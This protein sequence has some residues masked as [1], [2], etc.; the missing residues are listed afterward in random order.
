MKKIYGT[1]L[2]IGNGFDLNLGMVTDYRSFFKELQRIGFF[3]KNQTNPLLQFIQEK[4]VKENWYDF[5]NIIKEYA[6]KSPQAIFIKM[7]EDFLPKLELALGIDKAAFETIKDFQPLFYIAP[8]LNGIIEYTSNHTE[9]QFASDMSIQE[10]CNNI[11]GTLS[12]YV[13]EQRTFVKKAI[14]LL[15]TELVSYLK[16]ASI[17]EETPTAIWM[18]FAI[19]GVFST[20][21]NGL[22][23]N[24]IKY[25]DEHGKY[26]F[27]NFRIVSFNYTDTVTKIANWLELKHGMSLCVETQDLGIAFYRIHGDLK[28]Q[29]VF[30]IDDKCSIPK[31]FMFLRK[32]Q[33][34]SKDA[35]AIF[36]NIIENSDRIIIL[37][38]SIY[39]I[40]FEYYEDFFKENKD[41][42]VV[43]LY[44]NDSA[45]EA[46]QRGL[47]KLGVE[48][49]ITY[50]PLELSK[51]FRHYCEQIAKDQNKHFA[52]YSKC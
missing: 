32:S 34:I 5:E 48:H 2:I 24:F 30:G 40:D 38:H 37:G 42:E 36:R 35:K 31:A 50:K 51:T 39:G 23:E 19:M 9:Y 41:T 46:I 26:T 16:K 52:T 11:E 3:E 28:S 7:I 4:G 25:A 45:K 49:K 47:E 21:G 43:I 20:T 22:V 44:H 6:T 27:P 29:I 14:R 18:L 8:D 33:N 12:K 17:K 15:T 13:E 10:C 1:S